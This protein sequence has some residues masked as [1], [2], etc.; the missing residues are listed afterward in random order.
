MRLLRWIGGSGCTAEGGA[1][2]DPNQCRGRRVRCARVRRRVP[3]RGVFGRGKGMEQA[4]LCWD[5]GLREG[6]VVRGS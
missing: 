5:P 4:R 3:G 2:A 6:S 1:A